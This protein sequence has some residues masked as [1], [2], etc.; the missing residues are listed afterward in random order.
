MSTRR[1]NAGIGVCELCGIAF[2]QPPK[3]RNRKFCR[4]GCV[5]LDRHLAWARDQLRFIAERGMTPEMVR[6]RRSEW[7]ETANYLNLAK[8]GGGTRRSNASGASDFFESYESLTL[9][10]ADSRFRTWWVG[11]DGNL[12]SMEG[13]YKNLS[14]STM[15]GANTALWKGEPGEQGDV[16]LEFITVNTEFRGHGVGSQILTEVTRMA[17]EANLSISLEP[18]PRGGPLSGS[19]LESW[20]RRYGFET[21]RHPEYG[22]IE[23]VLIRYPAERYLNPPAGRGVRR[24]EAKACP[25]CG[26]WITAV[27]PLKRT[28]RLPDY[29]S[30]ECREYTSISKWVDAEIGGGFTDRVEPDYARKV[31]GRIQSLVNVAL[32]RAQPIAAE[33]LPPLEMEDA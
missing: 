31:R 1:S 21:L 27:R 17:D 8:L 19:D 7:G 10:H 12:V 24:L 18:L 23:E 13:N 4:E 26:V 33:L 32:N 14:D 9:P 29:C 16:H 20:Y 15:W 5:E 22:E 28:G 3:G 6:F 2:Q 30:D 25:V 11:P